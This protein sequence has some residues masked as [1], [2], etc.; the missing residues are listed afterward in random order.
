M[1]LLNKFYISLSATIAREIQ[2]NK[3]SIDRVSIIEID[4]TY[5]SNR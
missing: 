4:D 5:R 1:F 2:Y 3:F